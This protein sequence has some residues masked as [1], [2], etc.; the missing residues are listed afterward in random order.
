M[1]EREWW[2]LKKNGDALLGPYSEKW[3]LKKIATGKW[4]KEWKLSNNG[5]TF[6]PFVQVFDAEVKKQAEADEAKSQQ[7]ALREEIKQLQAAERERHIE[8]QRQ[9]KNRQL[10]IDA[11]RLRQ[12]NAWVQRQQ[13]LHPGGCFFAETNVEITCSSCGHVGRSVRVTRPAIMQDATK[14]NS[15][16]LV[17]ALVF[18]AFVSCGIG[19]ILYFLYVLIN[20]PQ[21]VLVAPA[22]DKLCCGNCGASI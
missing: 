11:G 19:L 12:Q 9:I 13:S 17:I 4:Q 21:P 14:D 10:E 3:F 20:K 22:I 6:K 7:L 16:L 2:L 18:I 5:Q 1:S 8:E 15:C